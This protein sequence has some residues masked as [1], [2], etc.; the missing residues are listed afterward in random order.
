MNFLAPLAFIG[1]ALALPIVAMYMLKL[2]RQ[3]RTISSTFLWRQVMQDREANAP[4]QRLRP[5][6]LLILQLL[7][8]T[9]LVLALARPF[10]NTTGISTANLILIVDRSASMAATDASGS[11]LDA[12]KAEANRLIDQLPSGGHA[13]LITVGGQPE[14]PLSASTDRRALHAA[15]NRLAI[16]YGGSDA[17]QALA[18]AD[19]LAAHDDQSQIAIVSD[20]QMQFPPNAELHAEVHF[21]PIGTRS[22]NAAISAIA[23]ESH[24]GSQQLFV[25]LHNYDTTAAT[26]RVLVEL[27]GQLFNAYD[28]QI[29]PAGDQSLLIDVPVTT[30][31]ASARFA[32][33]DSFSLDDQ[34]WAVAPDTAKTE[35]TLVTTGN[36][37]LEVALNA[38][39]NVHLTQVPS[40]TT[41]FTTTALTVIDRIVP[42]PLPPGN[43]L[44]I[45]PPRS[46]PLWSVDG[47]LT[48]PI[49]RPQT[50]GDPVLQNTDIR[51]LH[52]LRAVQLGRPEW[53]RTVIASDGGPLLLIGEQGGRR[54]ALLSFALQESDLP[55]QL[56]FPLLMSNLVTELTRGQG[57]HAVDGIPGQPLEL[58]VPVDA[59]SA[60]MTDP[61]GHT[62]DLPIA[63]GKAISPP[64]P[65]PGLYTVSITRPGAQPLTRL[66]A[67][68]FTDA[69]ESQI[70]PRKQLPLYQPGN[71]P[72]ASTQERAARTELWRY[73]AAAALLLVALEWL[74]YHRPALPSLRRRLQRNP[75]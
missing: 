69:Q 60:A 5:S 50:V 30:R 34:A 26:R 31:Y 64:L 44:V 38:L 71:R 1:A 72:V 73:L 21:S 40:T 10:A 22:D 11:R 41:T 35:I 37:Y 56:A 24:A 65:T 61:A 19:A 59:T 47:T 42:D 28:L 75:R 63:N 23:L 25:Q 4:W 46:S 54:I 48:V 49:P 18:L 33:H 66:I 62:T 36:R 15:V 14:V 7:I 8:L 52:I 67:A 17:S 27:D 57:Q 20:G 32:S 74:A 13:T 43:L 6:L 51:D 2:R 58:S 29:P 45:A 12:A 55:L 3:E 70:A 53:A 39:P 16:R 68:N 9:S